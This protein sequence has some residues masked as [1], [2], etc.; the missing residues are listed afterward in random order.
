MRRRVR[1]RGGGMGAPEA[2]LGHE[3]DGSEDAGARRPLLEE[4]GDR[5]GGAAEG[6]GAGGALLVREPVHWLVRLCSFLGCLLRS[7]FG[8]ATGRV[9]PASITLTPRQEHAVYTV[10]GG[11]AG[12]TYDEAEAAHVDRLRRLWRASL[13]A[14]EPFPSAPGEGGGIRSERWKDMGWQG[15]DPGTDIRGGGVMGLDNLIYLSESYPGV[16]MK[17][18]HKV[19]ALL[20]P[21]RPP[22]GAA[23]SAGRRVGGEGSYAVVRSPAAG[24]PALILSRPR[25]RPVDR[26]DV[27][28]PGHAAVGGRAVGLGVSLL[29]RRHERDLH[30]RGR[31]RAALGG[32]RE[33]RRPRHAEAQ[34]GDAAR[35]P[36]D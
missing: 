26:G 24:A 7:I 4:D 36:G 28:E 31:L 29:G 15:V 6:E 19:R 14:D 34:Q 13:G 9:S 12:R 11:A 2:G 17:L 35:A 33:G 23:W 1:T 10:L 18:L 16:Y 22:S 20:R 30:A 5:P 21:P 8:V 32:G 25:A 3:A 27:A